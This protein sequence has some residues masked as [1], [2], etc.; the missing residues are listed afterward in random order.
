MKCG[1]EALKEED[2]KEKWR[3][4]NENKKGSKDAK[5]HLHGL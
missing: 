1:R 5:E 2:E 4:K 3:L